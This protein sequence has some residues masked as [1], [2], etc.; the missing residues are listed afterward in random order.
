MKFKPDFQTLAADYAR[1]R[2][3]YSPALFDAVLDYARAPARALDLACGTGLAA[4][5]LAARGLDVVGIDIAPAMLDAA[6]AAAPR[7]SKVEFV[8]GRAEALPFDD[9]VFDLVTCAQAFH[10]LDQSATLAECARVLRAGGALALWWKNPAQDDRYTSATYDLARARVGDE[11]ATLAQEWVAT[12]RIVDFDRLLEA[13]P[14]AESRDA[15]LPF[16]VPFTVESFVGL[17]RSRESLRIALGA[18]RDRFFEEL[19]PTIAAL[20]PTDGRFVVR[21]EQRLY[22]ARRR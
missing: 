3:S 1:F 17:Q 16:D 19:P 9:G 8:V 2:T 10:W 22:T 12:D 18:Q 4:L 7:G 15:M 21:H 14:F 5:E 11:R 20:A 13:F 6:R